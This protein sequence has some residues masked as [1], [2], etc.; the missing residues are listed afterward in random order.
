MRQLQTNSVETPLEVRLFGR[1]AFDLRQEHDI[2]TLRRLT[3]QG[4]NIF[5]A[6]PEITRVRDDWDDESFLVQLHIDPDRASLDCMTNQDVA[7]SSFVRHQRSVSGHLSHVIVLFDF[8]EERHEA[9]EPFI[10][11]L[12]DAGMARLHPVLMMVGARC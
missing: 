10:E 4:R 11:S 6:I 2:H 9:G 1:S 8:I 5:H 7:M 12:L 3:G